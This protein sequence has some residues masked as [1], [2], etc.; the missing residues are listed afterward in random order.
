MVFVAGQVPT[1]AELN[2]AL[3]NIPA[4]PAKMIAIT[5]SRSFLASEVTGARALR[6]WCIGGGGGGGITGNAGASN[7]SVG[8]GGCGGGMAIR[9]IPVSSVSFPVTATVGAGGASA[10]NGGATSFGSYCAAGGGQ[11]GQAGNVSAGAGISAI[12]SNGT[13]VGT[14]GDA[15]FTGQVGDPGFRISGTVA[16]AGKGGSSPLGSAN[17]YTGFAS[18]TGVAAGANTGSGGAGGMSIAGGVQAGGAGGSGLIMVE[19][20]Y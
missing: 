8:S 11:A 16:I 15:L 4:A 12:S 2:T 3:A 9:T 6:I 18:G 7:A 5:A 20:I 14:T 10:T 13:G 1:A 17:T 19:V